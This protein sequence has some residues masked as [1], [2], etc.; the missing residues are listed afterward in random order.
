MAPCTDCS[1]ANGEDWISCIV[2]GSA[3]RGSRRRAVGDGDE[4]I[5][6]PVIF[7]GSAIPCSC[8][9]DQRMSEATERWVCSSASYRGIRRLRV[10]GHARR[11][12]PRPAGRAAGCEA[13]ARRF[14]GELLGLEE[15]EAESL[16]ARGGVWFRIG[17]AAARRRR[18]GVRRRARN[19][20]SPPPATTSSSRGSA[21][22]EWRS[23]RTAARLSD[24]PQMSIVGLRPHPRAVLIV[25]DEEQIR[26]LLARLRGRGRPRLRVHHGR[27]G[28]RRARVLRGDALVL[29]DVN[30][31]ASES[32]SPLVCGGTTRRLRRRDGHRH[33]RVRRHRDRARRLRLRTEALQAEEVIINVGNALRRR[34]L[35]IEPQAAARS[36]R[37]RMARTTAL[38]DESSDAD[39]AACARKRSAG[40]R[41]PR[42]S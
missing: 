26:T 29:S 38:R 24:N 3:R 13:E 11:H 7:T 12:R 25:N 33:G 2:D 35:E 5:K 41:G 23:L 22:P 40:S 19:R 17:R 27:V 15:L 21:L 28:C 30:M 16:R 42:S 18:A 20:P 10:R 34:T 1:T 31:P 4:R 36:S 39:F 32:T 9:S 8:A 37:A 14:F 6:L